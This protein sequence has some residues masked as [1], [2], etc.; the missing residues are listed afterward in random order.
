MKYLGAAIIG[1]VLNIVLSLLQAQFMSSSENNELITQFMETSADWIIVIFYI[2]VILV[3]PLFEE[4]LFRGG[5]WKFFA[6]FGN[7]KVAAVVVAIIF[8]FLHS[9]EAAIFL[10]PFSVY[11]SYLRYNNGNIW[12]G[13]V[14]HVGFNT[15]GL[16][17]P[18]LF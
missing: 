12:S 16:L 14:A 7:D 6:H 13:V 5:I 11:L 2:I 17:L 9:W 3:V 18:R 4:V 15:A 8:T 1:V 10:L